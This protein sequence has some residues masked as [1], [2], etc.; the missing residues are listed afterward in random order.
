MYFILFKIQKYTAPE[1]N[2]DVFRKTLY[3]YNVKITELR[4]YH[5][6]SDVNYTVF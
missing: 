2:N 6:I 1:V 3:S 4:K 5:Y